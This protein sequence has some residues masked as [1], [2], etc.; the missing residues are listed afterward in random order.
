MDDW[1]ASAR[2]P[3]VALS[4]TPDYPGSVTGAVDRA[5]SFMDD[6][7]VPITEDRSDGVRRAT[8]LTAGDAITERDIARARAAEAIRD[9][10]MPEQRPGDIKPSI[11]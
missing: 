6:V 5:R 3:A 9:R 4:G 8:A 7:H 1:N 10:D 2:A 11:A